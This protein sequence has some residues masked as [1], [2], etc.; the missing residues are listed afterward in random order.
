MAVD[1][2]IPIDTIEEETE[3]PTKTYRLDLD[4]GR[5]I[6]TV[7]GIEAVNQA[8]IKAII[9]ARYKCLIYDDDYG[10]ELKDMVYDEVSTPELIETALPELVRDAL[11]QDT[12]ILDVYDFEISFKNDEAFIVFK[13][14]TVFGETPVSYTH[15]TLPTIA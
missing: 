1:I 15:L 6:G 4:S 9:T 5:I 11:S 2:E 12:R 13:A 3:K 8:I 7:D 14:D 10:G